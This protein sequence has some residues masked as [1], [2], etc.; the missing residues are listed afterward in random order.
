[1]DPRFKCNICSN[2]FTQ[3]KNLQAHLD[4]NRCKSD[5]LKENVNLNNYLV[6]KN[7]EIINKHNQIQELQVIIQKE[8]IDKN[9]II[10]KYED[11]ITELLDKIKCSDININDN[12]FNIHVTLKDDVKSRIDVSKLKQSINKTI[13]KACKVHNYTY[14][15]YIFPSG[16]SVNYQG[17]ENVALDELCKIYR[18]EDIENDRKHI[19][20]VKYT[21][22]NKLHYYYPDIYIKSKNLIIEV[23]S[24]YTYK[25]YLIRN[26]IKSLAVK[27]A[28]YNFEFWIYSDKAKTKIIIICL[29][30]QFIRFY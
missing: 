25:Q 17:Y 6:D 15:K 27:K 9:N 4:N 26:I 21:L 3:K 30:K 1:M 10:L 19:P 24:N 18:E 12:M 13:E 8:N 2:T 29:E 11:K 23:K 5:L 16:K 20:N 22:K 28:G 14:K 7:N